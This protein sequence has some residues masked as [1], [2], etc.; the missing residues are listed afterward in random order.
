M[1]CCLQPGNGDLE[2]KL[3]CFNVMYDI[4]LSF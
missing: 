3:E 4:V 2:A 1:G